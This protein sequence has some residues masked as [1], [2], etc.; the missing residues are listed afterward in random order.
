LGYTKYFKNGNWYFSCFNT[1]Q[2]RFL[3]FH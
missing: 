2:L 1:Q 3:I